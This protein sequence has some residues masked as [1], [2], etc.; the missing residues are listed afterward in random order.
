MSRAEG[1][2]SLLVLDQ[3]DA[4]SVASRRYPERLPIVEG[5]LAE[6]VQHVPARVVHPPQQ[7]GE[8]AER[9]AMAGGAAPQVQLV[10]MVLVRRDISLERTPHGEAGD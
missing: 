6:P 2:E 1:S 10:L 9:R 4:V 8:N 7:L 5:L 3:L